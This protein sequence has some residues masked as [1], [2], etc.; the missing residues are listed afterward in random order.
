MSNV[1]IK[2]LSKA[3]AKRL[4]EV[5]PCLISAQ[6]TA[7]VKNRNIGESGRLIS[8]I[9]EIANT[10]KMEGFLV[11]M[12]VEKAFDSL[13]HTFLISVLKRF[14]FGQNFV[15]WIEIILKNQE[16]CVING[17]TTTKYFKLNRGACQGDPISAYL[18]ILAFEILFLL[19]KE[20]PHIKGLTIFDHCYLYSTHADS[21]T[22]FLKDVNSTKEMVVF[23]CEIAGI[24]VLKWVKEAVCGIQCVDLVLDTIKI[25]GPHF[26]YN[27]K[28]RAE[29]FLFDH[30]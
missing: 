2:I 17:G 27:E 4:K 1:D 7:Y 14:G 5:L 16:S 24:G 26:S 25:V 13:D 29:K 19:I 11:T 12:D 21:T 18:F 9:I 30:S 10:R 23:K 8:D 20:N 15:S 6:Q 22:S 28:L 3:L